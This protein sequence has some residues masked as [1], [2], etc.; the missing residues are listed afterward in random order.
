MVE[1]C[2]TACLN[3]D[4]SDYSVTLSENGSSTSVEQA[5]LARFADQPRFEYRDNR[6]NL[7]FAGAHNLFIHQTRAEFVL[8]L[9][10]DAVLSPTY[11]SRLLTAFE[12]PLV[13]AAEGKMLK[14]DPLPDGSWVLDGTG[15][16]L[17]R[18]RKAYERGHLEIDHGQYDRYT[19]IFGVSGTA[20]AYR[21]TAL[22]KVRFGQDEYFDKDFFTYWEDL[23]L[24]WR[25]RLAGFR[26]TYVPGAILFHARFASQSRHGFRRPAK[27]IRHMRTIPVRVLQWD[28]R[29]HLFAIIKNDF[30]R[31]LIRD[32]PIIIA[33][34]FTLLCFL[35]IVQPRVL[36]ALPS[37]VRLLPPML[38]KRRFVQQHRI[39]TSDQMARWI[40]RAVNRTSHT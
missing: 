4:H 40:G 20:A 16:T 29:N 9:N 37:F 31:N 26:S 38:R 25:L 1:R 11:L 12:D 23:D 3:Q 8:P 22:K 34:E 33:R 6:A 13:A 21:V 39:A 36:G 10:P 5:I 32:L 14:P 35:T 15:M 2:I 27:L 19:D 17:T 7:G 18:A 28:W 24:A 30:G